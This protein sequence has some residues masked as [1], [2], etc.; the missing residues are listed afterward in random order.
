LLKLISPTELQFPEGIETRHDFGLLKQSLSYEDKR[1]S[2]EYL[3]WRKLQKQDDIFIKNGGTGYRNWFVNKY[4]RTAL[5]QKV[6]ELSDKRYC[7]CLYKN[8]EHYYTY[9]GLQSV[10]AKLSLNF[11]LV[12]DPRFV[13]PEDW[14]LIPWAK[15]PHTPRWYQTKAVELLCPEDGSRTH[16]AVSIG[17]GLGKSLIMAMLVKRVGLEAIIVVPTLSIANQMLKDFSN[18][19]G[20]GKVGQFFDGKKQSDRHIVIAV[21]KSLMNVKKDT[22]DWDN[23]FNRMMVLCDESHTCPPDSLASV[24]FGLLKDIPYRYFFSGTQFR[25]DG[26]G[27]LLQGITGDVVFEMSV[28]QGIKEGFLSPLK[29][30]QWRI[31]SDS[32]LKCDDIIK[33]NKVHLQ[34]NGKIY[35]HAAN[36]INR[37]VKEKN[38]KVL[39]LVDTVDQYQMLLNGGLAV[40][41]RF[42][43][44]PLS[45]NKDTVPQ[46][47]WKAFDKNEFPVLVGTGCISMGT[48]VKSADFLV[49]IV[50]L[51]SEI[52]VSQ[53]VGRGTRLFPGKVDCQYHDYW[54]TNIDAMDRH[55]KKRKKIFESIYGQCKVLEA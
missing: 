14:K 54:V 34:Q 42:A 47:Q 11:A 44:G 18:W 51:T 27:L 12:E 37:A 36:L 15:T 22:K 31:T 25:N 19:F 43:H 35:K 26:L 2:Y 17:T 38:R 3:K 50:G 7:S 28:E 9:S 55:A 33:M 10:L 6:K 45:D 49:N 52:E 13:S 32:S 40:D 29:F 41:S 8:G 1:I 16:G 4:G 5:D 20:K 30:F 39:V 23:I 21:S 46:S 48:D 24:M 53:G